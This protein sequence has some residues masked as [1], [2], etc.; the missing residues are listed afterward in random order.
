MVAQ[1]LARR[2][3]RDDH[4]VLAGAQRLERLGLVAVERL[5]ALAVQCSDEALVQ[6]PRELDGLRRALGQDPMVHER[7][8]DFRLGEQPLERLDGSSR[9]VDPHRVSLPHGDI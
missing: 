6:P 1:R 4:D 9:L 8:F 2:G 3:R 5:D 7:G